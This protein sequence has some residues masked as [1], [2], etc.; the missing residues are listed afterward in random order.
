ML[1]KRIRMKIIYPLSSRRKY[2]YQPTTPLR[3]VDESTLRRQ[4]VLEFSDYFSLR[5]SP[6]TNIGHRFFDDWC[7]NEWCGFYLFMISCL[8]FYLGKG[9]VDYDRIEP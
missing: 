7:E 5:Y 4:F 6:R 3:G 2:Y 8:R 1:R 9:L